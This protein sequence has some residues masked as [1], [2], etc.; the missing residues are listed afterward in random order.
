M[1]GNNGPAAEESSS[2]MGGP[3]RFLFEYSLFL[4]GGA[5]IALVWANVDKSGYDRLIHTPIVLQEEQGPEGPAPADAH[6]HALTLHVLVNDV[7]MALFFAIAAKEVWESLLPGGA[8]SR[9]RRA[10]TPLMA[11]AGGVIVPAALYAVGVWATGRWDELGR[12]WAVPCATDIAFS[13]LVARLIFGDG[14]P[15]IPFLLLLAIADDAAGLAILAVFYPTQPLEPQWLLLTAGAVASGYILRGLGVKS[16]WWYLLLPGIMSWV[17]FYQAGIHA[18]LGLVPIIPTM[19]H[20]HGDI[21]FFRDDK[22]ER[23]DTLSEFEHWW[24]HPVELILGLFGLVNAGVAFSNVGA[25]TAFV[26]L[27]LVV[28]KPLG[29]FAFT[30]MATRLLKL[31]IPAG[32]SDRHV[33]TL[34]VVAGIGFTVALFVATTAFPEP[35]PVQDAVKMGALGSFASAA[36]AFPVARLL[37][38]KRLR[39]DEVAGEAADAGG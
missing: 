34:G 5:V 21:G 14:H 35:G 4:I 23:H 39:A 31:E 33:L 18:A 26:M 27:G 13:Y 17:S 8:L 9:P 32:M 19:P 36:L 16:F 38:V 20:A 25:G 6:G 22:R 15:A 30:W 37:G 12:G 10:A 3:I 24:D 29:I 11:T 2:S 28:G 7:L 1:S